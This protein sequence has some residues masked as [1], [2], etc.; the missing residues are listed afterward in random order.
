MCMERISDAEIKSIGMKSLA[1]A[2]GPVGA[3]R[4]VFIMNKDGSDYTMWRR[5]IFDGMPDEEIVAG[6]KRYSQEHPCTDGFKKPLKK[7]I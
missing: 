1:D 7:V 4:F 2:L 6:A 5:S 3:E